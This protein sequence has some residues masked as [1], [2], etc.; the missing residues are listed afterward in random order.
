MNDDEILIDEPDTEAIE[1][2]LWPVPSSDDD[3]L[4]FEE[5]LMDLDLRF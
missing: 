5:F 3:P 2:E 4:E 1:R